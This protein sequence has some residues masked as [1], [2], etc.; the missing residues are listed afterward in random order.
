[1]K[2]LSNLL[3]LLAFVSP[4]TF[5]ADATPTADAKAP[6]SKAH[7]LTRAE[8]D[9]LLA[10]PEQL[11]VIDVRRPDELTDKGGF[12]VYLSIQAKDLEK[13][14]AYIPKD[15]KIVTVS[16]HAGRAGKAADLLTDKGFKVIGAI[17]VETYASEGGTLTKIT[18]PPA[19]AADAVGNSAVAAAL[20][21]YRSRHRI[22]MKTKH[23]IVGLLGLAVFFSASVPAIAHHAFSAEFD[24][25]QPIEIK[26]VVTKL[27][28]VNPHS[29]LYLDVKNA[30]GTVSNWGF[31]FGAPFSLKEKGVTK[32][33][34][35]A[36]TPITING[37]RSKSGKDY[38]YAVTTTLADGRSFQTGGAQ[39]APTAPT[40]A[41]Q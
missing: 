21:V 40:P 20:I 35:A 36:G 31:E 16:N 4:V 38:G 17:G 1:M 25:K 10:K 39:D 6:A 28:L 32:A 8:F 41:A 23:K 3:L 18:P 26:G 15:R 33:T 11:V 29:W 34:L 9:T 27:E 37:F 2:K 12:P 14:L 30:D 5:A 19:K 24:A 22:F 13:S 7:I